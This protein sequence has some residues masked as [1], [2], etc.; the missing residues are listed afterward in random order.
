MATLGLRGFDCGPEAL[1]AMADWN[2]SRRL[3]QR[4]TLAR[5]RA[6]LGDCRR[7]PLAA[8]RN[9]IVFGE[10]DEAARLVFVGEAPGF[11]E[12]QQ[13]RPFVGT[14]GQL[15]TRMITAMQLSREQVYICNILKCRPPGNRNPLPEEI[16]ACVPFLKRQLGAI[17]PEAIVAL[18]KFAA[19]FLLATEAPI[20]RL[21]G[22]FHEYQGI[23][24]MPTFHP[25]FLLHNPERKRDV[26]EDLKQVM[27]LLGLS[28]DD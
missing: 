4:E 7:C 19:Q 21:R 10:G 3:P 20:S 9:R 12:D 22:R 14:A 2:R 15:L 17:R 13:G 23:K 24:V 1:G 16:Q 28:A 5:I 25:A 26:W 18:G 8:G 6:D 27:T 11:H